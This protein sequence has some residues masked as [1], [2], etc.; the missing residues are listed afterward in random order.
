MATAQAGRAQ[1]G[2]TSGRIPTPLLNALIDLLQ[3]K[4]QP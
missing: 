3:K 2:G 1:S 4:A